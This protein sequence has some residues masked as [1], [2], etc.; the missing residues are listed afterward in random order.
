MTLDFEKYAQDGN[1][2]INELAKEL[3]WPDDRDR[4]AR[5]L[6][7]VLYAIRDMLPAAEN[8]QLTAQLPMML[9][10]VYLDGYTLRTPEHKP[11][12]VDDFLEHVKRHCGRTSTNDFKTP[13]DVENAVRTVFNTLRQYVSPGEMEDIIAHLPRDIKPLLTRT[14]MH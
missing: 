13:Y 2:F 9:K 8:L 14:A 11:R 3:N 1:R 4:A 12:H 5:V 6:R 7:A 10:S